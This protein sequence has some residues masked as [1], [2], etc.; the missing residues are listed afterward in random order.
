MPPALTPGATIGILAPASPPSD[1]EKIRKGIAYL[2]SHG[3]SVRQGKSVFQEDGYLSGSDAIRAADINEMF[4]AKDV[5]A[6]ICTRGG[7]GCTRLLHL[8]DY[9]TIRD[10]PK[11]FVGFSDV[12]ALHM[13]FL[14][15]AKLVS[16]AGPMLAVEMQSGI[17]EFTESH[18]WG[19]LSGS[20]KRK[21]FELPLHHPSGYNRE[22]KARGKL[23]GGNLAVFCSLIGTEYMPDCDN[24]VLY[25]EDV[26]EPVYK[27]DRMFS[28]LLHSGIL[29]RLSGV[30]LGA[31]TAIPDIQPDRQL[32]EVLAGYLL[33]LNIPVL[34]GFPFG[35]TEDKLTL[36]IGATVEFGVESRELTY[37]FATGSA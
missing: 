20:E 8:L 25:L 1:P 3:Y 36:P 18:F 30:L 24:A 29:Q 11:P 34:D 35:H 16:F 2:E 31:F 13:A 19:M 15:K 17:S 22:G 4:A 14:A 27:I 28:Q 32:S 5:D 33:P 6:I 9:D 7:Y 21:R 12:T 10:N 26:A 37:T 23:I